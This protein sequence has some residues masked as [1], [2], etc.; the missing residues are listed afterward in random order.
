MYL[1]GF[2]KS[3]IN[4]QKKL[5]LNHSYHRSLAAPLS[6]DGVH[7]YKK[8]LA[9]RLYARKGRATLRR[10]KRRFV[11]SLTTQ[12]FRRV[13]KQLHK[14]LKQNVFFSKLRKSTRARAASTRLLDS[15]AKEQENTS[16]LRASSTKKLRSLKRSFSKIVKSSNNLYFNYIAAVRCPSSFGNVFYRRGSLRRRVRCA[17]LLRHRTSLKPSLP[18]V[19]PTLF[20]IGQKRPRY[21]KHIY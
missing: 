5:E 7:I 4:F 3:L 15:L 18:L 12:K 16:F 20:E 14:A 9:R 10:T 8:S 11:R 2:V 17:R 19:L 21:P 1:Q 6:K 13:S